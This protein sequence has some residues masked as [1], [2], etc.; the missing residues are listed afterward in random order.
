MPASEDGFQGLDI[1]WRPRAVNEFLKDL[2]QHLGLVEQI[3]AA[4]FQLPDRIAVLEVQ[5]LLLG[6]GQ[7]K[8]QASRVEPARTQGRQLRTQVGPAQ[9][10]GQAVDRPGKWVPSMK[11]LPSLATR[12]F[13][14]RACRSTHSCPLTMTWAPQGA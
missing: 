12:T 6:Q 1:Q 8:T 11:Q 2:L 14:A 7:G 5:A 3:V 4:V 9:G 13:W 10:A